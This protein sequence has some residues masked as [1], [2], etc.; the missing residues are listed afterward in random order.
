[1]QTTETPGRTLPRKDAHSNRR[2]ILAAARRKLRE[3]P[4]ASLDS[5]SRAAGVARRTLY[6]HF[7]SRQ[8]LIADLTHEAGRELRQAFAGARTADAGPVE[9]MARMVLAAW[10][11]GD[12]YRTLI[13]LGRRHLG[14]DEIRTTL[15]PARAE[16]VATLRRGQRDG[17]FADHLP[18]PV[19]AR[20]LEALMLALAEENA[21]CPWAD[22]TGEAAA[23]AFLVAA[24]VAPLGAA[25]QVREVSGRVRAAGAG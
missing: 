8:A 18:A 6:G 24:G 5:I 17:V 3:D 21:A 13:A 14:A 15:A 22:A 10:T 12:H 4:D 19:L 11:V 25:H 7:P 16:V 2:R 23:T 20:A 1:M 9:A